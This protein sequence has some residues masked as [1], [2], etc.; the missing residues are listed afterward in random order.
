MPCTWQVHVC[1]HLQQ[2]ARGCTHLVLWLDCDREG[3]NICFEV[4]LTEWCI[5]CL[6][7][8]KDVVLTPAAC[9]GL[10]SL[11]KRMKSTWLDLQVIENTVKW[12]ARVPGQQVF[13]AR[14]SAISAPEL[15]AAMVL[16]LTHHTLR[17]QDSCTT[18]APRIPSKDL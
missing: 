2:E 10:Y 11:L 4:R 9:H 15:T 14:F 17:A 1:K 5:R 13:R 18:Y 3:E 6:S 8:W 16:R 12:M 7:C